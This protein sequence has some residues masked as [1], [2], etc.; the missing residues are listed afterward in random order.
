MDK[1][2]L[3]PYVFCLPAPPATLVSLLSPEHTR[4]N[5]PQAQQFLFLLSVIVF[6]EESM[7]LTPSPAPDLFLEYHLFN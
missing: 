1:V 4:H 6:P 2:L 7:R 5:P 3:L